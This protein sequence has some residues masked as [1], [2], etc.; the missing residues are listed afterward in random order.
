MKDKEISHSMKLTGSLL[1]Y[2][3]AEE[4]KEKGKQTTNFDWDLSMKN[5]NI[6][7]TLELYDKDGKTFETMEEM[8]FSEQIQALLNIIKNISQKEL[9]G[10]E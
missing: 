6:I 1:T 7:A 8:E 9:K 2:L 3:T 5:M 4:L 10:S